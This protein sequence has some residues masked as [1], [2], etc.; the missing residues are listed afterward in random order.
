MW[1]LG[2]FFKFC[3]YWSQCFLAFFDFPAV[4]DLMAVYVMQFGLLQ[5]ARA[6]QP[7]DG[8]TLLWER[9]CAWPDL[10]VPAAAARLLLASVGVLQWLLRLGCLRWKFTL[11]RTSPTWLKRMRDRVQT[12]VDLIVGFGTWIWS[13][14]LSSV[15]MWV[16]C[17]FFYVQRLNVSWM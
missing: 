6:G 3:V 10:S 5:H 7:L 11:R 4:Y 13:I 2:H 14:H 12:S 9:L 15:W 8:A 1:F 16:G 17:S